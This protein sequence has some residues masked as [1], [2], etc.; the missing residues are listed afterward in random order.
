MSQIP[1][2]RNLWF[3]GLTFV[4]AL[5]ASIYPLEPEHRW[6]RPQFVC[7][8]VIYWTFYLPERFG[9][10]WACLVGLVQ[11]FV[12]GFW[13]GQTAMGFLLVSYLCLLSYSR[14]R[15]YVWWQQAGWV[16]VLVGFQQLTVNWVNHLNGRSAEGLLFLLPAFTSALLWPPLCAWLS[17][18]CRRYRIANH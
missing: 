10:G 16:F 2:A 7:L 14:F 4:L 6:L 17:R 3:I 18:C 13:L 15:N 8:L 11:D 5:I 9:M 12:S 1:R